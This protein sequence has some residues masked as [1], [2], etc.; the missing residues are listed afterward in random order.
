MSED[1][2]FRVKPGVLYLVSTPIGNLGD[3]T[4][5]TLEVLRQVDI[6]AAE[7]T[8][9][10]KILLQHFQIQKP[11]MSYHDFNK[12]KVTPKLIE[13][14]EQS[15][16]I[17]VITD[18]GTPGISDPAFYLV[19]EAITKKIH[20]ESIPGATAFVPALILSGLPTDRFIFEGFL[21]AKKGR[22][23]RLEALTEEQR[24]M[25]FYESPFRIIRTL[26][27]LYNALGDRRAAIVREISKKF[28]EIVRGNLSELAERESSLTLK[29][30]FVLVVEGLTRE[31]IKARK[32]NE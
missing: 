7:D 2:N 4:L 19:R 24:T 30:E 13:N 18:A 16:S 28:E 9:K 31:Q 22:Q 8:R 10:S 14:L 23:T 6:I 27:D 25:I 26:K 29:G 5:R 1:S 11:M 20:I 15:Q 3:I 21:P 17:A 32:K 12:E